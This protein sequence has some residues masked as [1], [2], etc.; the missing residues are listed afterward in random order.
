MRR[1]IAMTPPSS[2][3][4]IVVRGGVNRDVEQLTE[5]IRD[6][7]FASGQAVLSVFCADAVAGEDSETHLHRVCS[8]S[9]IRHGQVQLSTPEAIRDAGLLLE[10]DA[11]GGQELHHHHVIFNSPVT[12]SQVRAFVDA[13]SEPRPNPTGGN[14][15]RR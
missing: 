4:V 12:E 8:E 6:N 1:V 14:K 10:P 5:L 2:H 3:G 9:K 7:E 11:S 15:V 13:F